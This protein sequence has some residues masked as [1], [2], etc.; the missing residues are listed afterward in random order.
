[1]RKTR[2]RIENENIKK[3]NEE[4]EIKITIKRNKDQLPFLLSSSHHETL[5][6]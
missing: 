4:K 6:H 5:T 2:E 1:M 3:K